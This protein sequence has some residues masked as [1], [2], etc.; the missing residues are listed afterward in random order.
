M[1][2]SMLSFVRNNQIVFQGGCTI[3]HSHHQRIRVPVASA[4][5]VI[6]NPD[7][8]HFKRC[9]VIY[10]IVVVISSALPTYVEYPLI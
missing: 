5:G 7:F 2:K 10:L 4:Y 3:L 8:G 6:S 9:V 1:V